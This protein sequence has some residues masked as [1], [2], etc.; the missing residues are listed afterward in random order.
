MFLTVRL[1]L[2]VQVSVLITCHVSAIDCESGRR[3]DTDQKPSGSS[4]AI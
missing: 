1:S 3:F 4:R 2:A